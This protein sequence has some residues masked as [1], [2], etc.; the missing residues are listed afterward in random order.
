M[1][2]DEHGA[3]VLPP[4]EQSLGTGGEA[5]CNRY[6]TNDPYQAVAVKTIVRPNPQT[7]YLHE[8][9]ILVKVPRHPSIPEINEVF[10]DEY[11]RIVMPLYGGGDMSSLLR[12]FAIFGCKMPEAFVWHAF[13]QIAQGLHHLHNNNV[14]PVLHRDL[15]PE[16]LLVDLTPFGVL[17]DNIKITDFGMATDQMNPHEHFGGTPEYQPPECPTASTAADVYAVGACIHYMT[18][19]KQPLSHADASKATFNHS[20]PL[21]TK[22]YSPLLEHWMLRTLDRNA[23]TRATTAELVTSMA[24]DARSRSIST[25]SGF[26]FQETVQ[27]VDSAILNPQPDGSQRRCW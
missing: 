16:N 6:E 11:L 12:R 4:A 9:N 20:T 5:H 18:T 8:A 25:R 17:F 1:A 3:A 14:L 15:K 13:V 22:G 10:Q 27:H 19:D 21:P 26:L 24:S 2:T 7:D 23:S